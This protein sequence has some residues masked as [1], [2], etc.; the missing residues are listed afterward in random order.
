MHLIDEYYF[1]IHPVI[2][3]KG[4][5][6][7]ESFDLDTRV[8]LDLFDTQR[9]SSGAIALFYKVVNWNF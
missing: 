3:G 9:F 1:V 7:F 5:R 8:R 2:Y 4:K 6:F